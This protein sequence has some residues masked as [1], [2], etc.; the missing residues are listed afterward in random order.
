MRRGV[1]LS[2]QRCFFFHIDLLPFSK[3]GVRHRSCFNSC[4]PGRAGYASLRQTTIQILS[5]MQNHFEQNHF[6]IDPGGRQ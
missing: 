4:I 5:G 2:Y 1:E 6:E 3:K